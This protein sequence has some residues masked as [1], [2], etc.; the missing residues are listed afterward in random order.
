MKLHLHDWIPRSRVNGPGWRAAIWVQGCSLACPGCFNP[1]THTAEGG[2]AIEVSEL[3]ERIVRLRDT[4]EGVTVSGGEPLEQGAGVLELVRGIRR[5]TKLS[6]VVFSGYEIREIGS[7]PNRELL[8][9]IDVLIAGRYVASR[10]VARGLRGSANKTVHCLSS[11]YQPGDLEAVPEAEVI[12][13][14]EGQWVLS[15]IEPLRL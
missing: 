1:R 4:I 5:E 2:F 14:R 13:G 11:R 12:I 10:R 3:I 6:I 7:G 15:G 8:D 9:W